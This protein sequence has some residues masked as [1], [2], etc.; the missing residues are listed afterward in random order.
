MKIRHFKSR[1]RIAGLVAALALVA[2]ASGA[3]AQDAARSGLPDDPMQLASTTAPS[4]A[5]ASGKTSW[6][7]VQIVVYKSKRSLALYRFGNFYRE[8]PV[9]LGANPLGRK[10][11]MYDA[12]TPEGRYHVIDKRVH[13]RWQYFLAIDYPNDKDQQIYRDEA[14][15]NLIPREDDGSLFPI[16]GSVGIHGNDKPD[17]QARGVDWTQGCVALQSPDIAEIYSLVPVGTPVWVVK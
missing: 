8:Y 11:F 3:R 9:V 12:R 1:P 7:P 5:F 10:R 6:G 15:R 13:D 2:L 16:G 14:R 4:A 17:E